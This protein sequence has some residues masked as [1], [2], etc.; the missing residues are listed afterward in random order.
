MLVHTTSNFALPR[1]DTTNANKNP[2]PYYVGFSLLASV[3]LFR[4]NFQQ[5]TVFFSP[6]EGI[7]TEKP[8]RGWKSMV[9]DFRVGIFHRERMRS[10]AGATDMS[11]LE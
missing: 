1:R 11:F 2:T 3:A 8:P 7:H 9:P 10:P 6:S 5:A 4:E